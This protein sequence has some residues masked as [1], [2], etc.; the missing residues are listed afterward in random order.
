MQSMK[1]NVTT[2][3]Q[4]DVN[5][6]AVCTNDKDKPEV[7]Y[8]FD[9]WRESFQWP[10]KRITSLVERNFELKIARTIANLVT[11]RTNDEDGH[12]R[13]MA[14]DGTEPEV[15]ASVFVAETSVPD[16]EVDAPRR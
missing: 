16:E 15:E 7:Q 4:M 3:S 8:R 6:F 1:R 9:Q 5:S 13:A 11:V 10:L 12:I 14:S 2:D